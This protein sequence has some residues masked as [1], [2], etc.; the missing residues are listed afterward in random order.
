MKLSKTILTTAGVTL[1]SSAAFAIDCNEPQ[2][3]NV[4]DGDSATQSQMDQAKAELKDF[5][6]ESQDYLGCLQDKAAYATADERAAI[7]D[8]YEDMLD[9]IDDTTE[10]MKDAADDFQDEVAD[11]MAEADAATQDE[12]DAIA[13]MYSD[14]VDNLKTASNEVEQ[15]WNNFKSEMEEAE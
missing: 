15:A 8:M 9:K 13:N 3:P 14:M 10:D 6:Q 4:P 11:N 7:E 12:Q 2:M 5:T 1:F